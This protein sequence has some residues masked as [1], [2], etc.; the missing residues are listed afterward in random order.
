MYDWV[1]TTT[2]D[3]DGIYGSIQYIYVYDTY[4]P[5]DDIIYNENY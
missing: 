2:I 5:E 1:T 3:N 4:A